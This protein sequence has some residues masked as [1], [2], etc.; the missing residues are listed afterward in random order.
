LG[1]G[2]MI[3]LKNVSKIF[4]RDFDRARSYGFSDI[5]RGGRRP[6][7]RPFEFFALQNVSLQLAAG[8]S[9]VVFG[10][11]QSGKSTIARLL[12]GLLRPDIGQVVVAGRV[13]CPP[14]GKLGLNPYMTLR[15][16]VELLSAVLGVPVNRQRAY[17]TAV[18]DRCELGPLIDTRM[19]NFPR[20]A[21]RLLTMT[22]SLLAD[23][24]VFVFDDAYVAGTGAARVRCL[25]HVGEIVS[26]RTT[27]ILT[28]TPKLPPFPVDHAMILHEGR[29]LYYGHPTAMLQ[30]FDTLVADLKQARAD[31]ETSA[32]DDIEPTRTAVS[33]TQHLSAKNRAAR[34][35]MTPF[36]ADTEAHGLASSDK[37]I[38]LGPW[39]GNANWEL[40]YWRPY[41][42]W[43][44]EQLDRS[45]RRVIAV[46]RAGAD[47]WYQALGNEYVDLL[48]LYSPEEFERI[49]AERL[50]VT[51]MRKQRYISDVERDILNVV[52]RRLDLNLE[53]CDVVHPA[54]MFRMFD[55]V[56]RGRLPPD[57]VLQYCRFPGL[58]EAA[59]PMGLDLPPRYIA[60]RFSVEPTYG[61][62][63]AAHDYVNELVQAL[64]A[65]IPVVS[66]DTGYSVEGAEFELEPCEGLISMH[67]RVP[68]R[69]SL[70]LQTQVVAGASAFVGTL[71]GSVPLA[72]SCGVQTTG[73][74]LEQPG[75]ASVQRAIAELMS[76]AMGHDALDYVDMTDVSASTLVGRLMRTRPRA[77]R[78]QQNKLHGFAANG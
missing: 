48:D 34:T 47:V 37:P 2:A 60:V 51:G 15:E 24:D 17:L 45:R 59:P 20:A 31:A 27:V 67:D 65:R 61:D 4:C 13:Q 75:F 35:S 57:F 6:V 39:M 46:S 40:L 49:S 50:R 78:R 28:G 1:E 58:L 43:L 69:R 11:E 41:V 29:A 9:L 18:L 38:L 42:S 44:L 10:T 71:G 26:T 14:T 5:V 23:G 68:A 12:S 21:L 36:L 66:L 32:G 52:A 63:A 53:D 70:E 16:Y 54:T 55:E 8:E 62:R 72:M 76:V 56:W 74:Y 73:L 77:R 25:E 22:A 64:A 19:A 3:S 30:V 7:P 33:L